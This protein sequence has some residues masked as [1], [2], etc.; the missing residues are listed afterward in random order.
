MGIESR[1]D[2]LPAL[3]LGAMEVSPLELATVYATLAAGGRRPTPHLLRTVVDRQGR[4]IEAS[5]LGEPPQV[6]EPGVAYQVTRLLTGVLD[7]GTARG[8]RDQGLADPLAGKT[9]TT[10]SRR[11]SWF[12]GYSPERV[13]LVWV[14]YDDNSTSRLSGARAALPI[15]GRFTLGV[16]PPRGFAAFEAPDDVVELHIDPETGGLATDRCPTVVAEVFL[17]DFIPRA[18]CPRHA[19]FRADPLDQPEGVEVPEKENPFKRWIDRIRGKEKKRV[20]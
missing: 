7:R 5:P 17:R 8:V 11:D 20:Y 15:W 12:A 14:G 2:P 1:L 18:L 4:R 10:N 9:G 16:R 19:G 13:T 3:A 6:L